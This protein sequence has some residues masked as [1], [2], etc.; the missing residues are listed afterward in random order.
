ML[1]DQLEGQ[2]HPGPGAMWVTACMITEG[3]FSVP[4]RRFG[5][6]WLIG[7]GSF[8]ATKGISEKSCDRP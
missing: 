6:G 3:N 7:N 1:R 8:Y 4:A 5:S 2:D